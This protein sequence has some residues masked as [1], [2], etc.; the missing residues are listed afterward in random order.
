MD[1]HLPYVT[2]VTAFLT[3]LALWVALLAVTRLPDVDVRSAVLLLVIAGVC[4]A[5][6]VLMGRYESTKRHAQGLAAEQRDF[7]NLV[8]HELRLP[9]SQSRWAV[10][11]AMEDHSLSDDARRALR[12]SRTALVNATT[13]LSDLTLISRLDRGVMP[14]DV[15]E[16]VPL[17]EVIGDA[18]RNFDGTR[19]PDIRYDIGP[20]PPVE[21]IADKRLLVD[22]IRA[23]VT[24]ASE[25]GRAAGYVAIDVNVYENRGAC[26]VRISDGG[27][28]PGDALTG[29]LS[30]P[31]QRY[32]SGEET[33]GSVGIG[34]YAAK[35]GLNAAGASLIV[36]ELPDETAYRIRIP[37]H[38]KGMPNDEAMQ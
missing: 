3:V 15:R 17:Q 6:W 24:A 2:A 5:L 33:L 4:I 12:D 13:L 14:V 7:A 32:S 11:I 1:R 35:R 37:L 8:T 27:D 28:G 16:H 36:E 18:M 23:F 26:E 22:G 10:E 29:V 34:M 30:D 21:V 20:V 25:F 19:Y 38:V 9:L 31:H